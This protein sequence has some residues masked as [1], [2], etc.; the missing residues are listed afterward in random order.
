VTERRLDT[1]SLRAVYGD[2]AASYDSLWHPVIR[3]PALA[4]IDA[5]ALDNASRVVDVGAG[6]GA[7]T[8][9]LRAAAPHALVVSA[10][11]SAAMLRVARERADAIACL[12]DAG[13]LPLADASVDAVLLAYV[14]FHLLEP[15]AGV[16]EAARVVRPGGHVGTITWANEDPPRAA[17]IW[18]EILAGHGVPLL[19]EHGN[20]RGLD[21]E[22]LIRSLLEDNGLM[23]DRLWRAPIEHDFTPDTYLRM[24]TGGGAGRA[25]LAAADRTTSR[26]AV[27]ELQRRLHALAPSDFRFRGEVICATS[28]A[29]A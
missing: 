12:A 9:P 24:R 21:R 10:D 2:G 8:A 7:L 5:L 20:H 11:A 19:P 22:D 15:S 26:A 6:T 17:A 29:P 16:R 28:H 1:D 25:R 4:L 3:P 23:P 13:A 27:G 14:L 18:D